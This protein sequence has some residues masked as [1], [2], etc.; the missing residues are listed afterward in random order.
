MLIACI[1]LSASL[2][3]AVHDKPVLALTA[4]QSA[5]LVTDGIT[6]KECDK[7]GCSEGDPVSRLFIGRHPTW[8]RMAPAGAAVAVGQMWLAERMKTSRH[9][10]VRRLWWLPEVAGIAANS[11]AAANNERLLRRIATSPQPTAS[12]IPPALRLTVR[13]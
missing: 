4:V 13:P 1:L 9:K 3:R 8:S 2:C 12:A 11:V 7:P 6:T 10:W 5:A